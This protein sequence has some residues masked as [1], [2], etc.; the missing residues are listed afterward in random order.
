MLILT[1]DDVAKLLTMPE[2]I[3]A[4]RQAYVA[5]AEGRVHVP[6][7]HHVPAA[8]GGVGLVMPGYVPEAQ[9]YGVKFVSVMPANR[10]RGLPVTLGT[11]ML[12]DPATGVPLALI[13]ATYLTAFRTGA[14]TGVA[15]DLLARPDAAELAIIGTGGQADAQVWAVLAVRPV[16]HVRV[17]NR[18]RAKAE[19][20]CRRHQGARNRDGQ[21]VS[22]AVVDSPQEAVEP[23]DIV[24]AST[25]V[26]TPVVRGEWLKPGC[27]VNG[28]GSHD[29][30]MQELDEETIRRASVIA[31]DSRAGAL[32]P[33]DLS[34]P[35]K[36]GI[37]RESDIV[38]IG[39]IAQG[40]H[41]GRRSAEEVTVFKS[42]GHASQDL[43]TGRMVYEKALAA[44][45]GQAVSL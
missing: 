31:V 35:L 32:V 43:V 30:R 13:A 18:T 21:E 23:A 10:D 24:V 28:I 40:K 45:I 1:D 7:R 2:A 20:F 37:V 27:H 42:V 22:F 15:T 8:D 44:G 3:A 9:G 6:L 26:Y 19:D 16:T 34:I 12:F 38:E 4:S 14:G 29:P 17:Y 11:M 5:L 39:L 25:N 41:P 33:G 36:Q